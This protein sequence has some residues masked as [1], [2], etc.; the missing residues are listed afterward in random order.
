MRTRTHKIWSRL[1]QDGGQSMIEFVIVLPIL[2]TLLLGIVQFGLAFHDYLSITDATRVGAR[3]AAV[4]PTD[5]CGTAEASIQDDVA[6]WSEA[7]ATFD[8]ET[9]E[10]TD[11]GDPITITVEYPYEIRLPG[12]GFT[13]DL[14]ASATERLE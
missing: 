4:S 13:R 8:C 11:S 7:P 14:T 2:L 10:G 6:K 3:K 9:P 12:F 1:Q 5:P